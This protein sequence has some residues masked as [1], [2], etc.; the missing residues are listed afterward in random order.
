MKKEHYEYVVSSAYKRP[1]KQW[2][3]YN[4]WSE[5]FRRIDVNNSL[6]VEYM[7]HSK[8]WALSTTRVFVVVCIETEAE[9]MRIWKLLKDTEVLFM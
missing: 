6:L 2:I 5:E 8:R 1:S 9:A 7:S 3:E 4:T